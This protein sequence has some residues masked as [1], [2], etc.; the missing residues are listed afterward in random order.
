[1]ERVL[2][3]NIRC[4]LGNHE[5]YALDLW[6]H[7][8]ASGMSAGEVTHHAWV[9]ATLGSSLQEM[10]ARWPWMLEEKSVGIHVAF[11]H[12]PLDA[13]GRDFGPLV[14]DP[15]AS[16]LDLLFAPYPV[17]LAFCGH[18]H[19]ASDV[20]G[21]ARYVNPGSLGCYYEPLARFVTLDLGDGSYMLTTHAV[22]YDDTALL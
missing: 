14:V 15:S 4:V 21:C 5:A 8:E 7:D 3:A 22:P 9:Q 6:P 17:D 2:S 19:V 16:A 18:N 13:S 11:L 1:M 20:Q 12:Y 10:V